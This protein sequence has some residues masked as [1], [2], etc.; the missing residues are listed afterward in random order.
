MTMVD[1]YSTLSAASS[2]CSQY[3]EL[4]QACQQALD[5][6]AAR[7]EEAAQR[8]LYGKELGDQLTRL[9]ADF[10]K[11]YAVLRRHKHE[12]PLCQFA[13][14]NLGNVDSNAVVVSHQPQLA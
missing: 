2:F 10:A 8:C 1:T 5:S 12:C 7:R 6:W 9:Q 3:D 4:L 13:A 11:S 14:S